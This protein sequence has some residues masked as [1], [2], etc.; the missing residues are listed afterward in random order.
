MVGGPPP[1][2]LTADPGA[3]KLRALAEQLQVADRFR[4]VGA[5]PFGDMPRWYRSA[6]LLVAAP[7]QEQFEASALEAMACGVPMVGTAVGGLTETVVDGLTGDLVPAR[8]PRALGGALRRLVNDKVRRFAYAT[9]ALDRARQAY[10]LEAGR[11][12][13][14]LGLR[15]RGR[16]APEQQQRGRG[17]I[18]HPPTGGSERSLAGRFGG[19][20]SAA[21]LDVWQSSRFRT[22]EKRY[23]DTVAVRDVSF[24]VD[25]GEIFGILGPNGAGKTTTVECIAGL[26]TPDG[27]AIRVLGREP[28]RPGAAPA[29][30]GPAPGERAAGEAHRPRGARALRLLLSRT[31]PTG[32]RWPASSASPT[33]SAP[34]TPSCPA[35]RSSGSPSRSR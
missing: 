34:A 31:R 12:P 7:W 4:L 14:R 22:C 17:V 13:G 8:D 23:G 33:S 1:D 29:R 30:R 19:P 2:Q 15:D 25:R 27:G 21:T 20:R 10:S 16:P 26:R 5:V 6:D 28:A 11:R 35:A 18:P 3:R 24:T 9:A 32:G